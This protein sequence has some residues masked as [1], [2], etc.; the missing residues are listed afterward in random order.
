MN[1]MSITLMTAKFTNIIITMIGSKWLASTK[2]L[3]TCIG[4]TN[5]VGVEAGIRSSQDEGANVHYMQL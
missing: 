5:K 3:F 1:T 2:C 4:C